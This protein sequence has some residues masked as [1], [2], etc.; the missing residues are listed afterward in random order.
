MSDDGYEAEL[1]A[2][3]MALNAPRIALELPSAPAVSPEIMLEDQELTAALRE[4]RDGVL[5]RAE[6]AEDFIA[7]HP[8][9]SVSAAFLLGL[10]VGRLMRGL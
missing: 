5:R 2:L 9:A 4:L 8:A 1:R 3:Q 6:G 7:E 10:A